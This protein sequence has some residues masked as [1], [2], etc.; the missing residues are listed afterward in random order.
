MSIREHLDFYDTPDVDIFALPP[1]RA[2]EFFR[3]KGLRATT[4]WRDM[5][6]Q[7]HR[8]A[9][10][11]AKMADLDM[12]ADV[13][14][15]LQRAIDNGTPFRQWADSIIP[16]LQEKGWWG[17]Q[18]MVDPATGQEI[19]AQLGSP[20]RLQTIYRTN[21]QNAYAVGQW[22][23]IQASKAAAPYLM[24]DAIDDHRTRP[25]HAAW[26]GTVLPVDHDWWKTHYPPNGW[27]CRC[28][29][30]QMSQDELEELGLQVSKRAPRSTTTTTENPRTGKSVKV[31]AGVDPGWQQSRNTATAR[32][33]EIEKV[34]NEKA[35]AMPTPEMQAAAAEGLKVARAAAIATDSRIPPAPRAP[36]WQ[37]AM[38]PQDAAEWA[39]GTE[40]PGTFL[41]FTA[42]PAPIL[43]KGFDLG[44]V[45]QG[46]G[47]AFGPGVYL[48]PP[49]QTEAL[50]FYRSAIAAEPIEAVVKARKV[51]TVSIDGV[52]LGQPV[53]AG[54]PI[55]VATTAGAALDPMKMAV[56]QG[57]PNAE[58]KVRRMLKTAA[59]L[60]EAITLV[61][62]AEGYDAVVI[63]NV[64][65]NAAVGGT[66]VIVLDPANIV[67]INPA[68]K[69]VKRVK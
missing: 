1:E 25:E 4:S 68:A 21:M 23:E 36:I 42:N 45:G 53:L 33:L 41:H 52:V 18:R 24:Y 19:I 66:Q 69:P 31:P 28:G 43:H 55:R 9:F 62:L 17:R 12:L 46:A 16:M 7:E 35:Q 57:V 59:T 5:S 30:I 29:V 22:E 37:P 38:Q 48:V 50:A 56:L 40:L 60:D 44:K 27:N 10:T 64:P 47:A 51:H 32:S 11:I 39:A 63:Q 20:A 49:A 58:R 26:D 54:E 65:F 6:D 34:A 3:S 13:Q 8:T 67:A 14:A 61:L 2:A 15:S